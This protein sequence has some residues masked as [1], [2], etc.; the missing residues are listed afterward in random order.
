MVARIDPVDVDQ[1]Y[2]SQEVAL[3]FSAFN[4]RTTPEGRGNVKFV[5]ADATVDKNSGKTFYEATVTIDESTKAALA[6]LEL[7]PGMPVET[8]IKTDKRTPLSY[9]VQPLSVYFARAFREE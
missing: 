9:L 4:R 7:V 1:I 3:V 2:A 5:S 8:F 6:G